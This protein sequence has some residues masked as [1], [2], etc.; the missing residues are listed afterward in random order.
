MDKVGEQMALSGSI[1]RDD[2]R[3]GEISPTQAEHKEETQKKNPNE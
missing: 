1:A 3:S 2:F